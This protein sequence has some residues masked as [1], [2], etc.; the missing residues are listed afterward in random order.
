MHTIFFFNVIQ[1]VGV[2][3]HFVQVQV[4]VYPYSA[5]EDPDVLAI[6]VTH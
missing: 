3:S 6:E 1:N 2:N 4:V 5:S